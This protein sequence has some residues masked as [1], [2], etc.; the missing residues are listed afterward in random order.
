MF[1]TTARRVLA[2]AAS[3]AL[4]VPLTG[5]SAAS[6]SAD[7]PAPGTVLSSTRFTV[8]EELAA[9]TGS[10]RRIVYATTDPAGRT[11]VASGV[12]L[13]PKSA[14]RPTSSKRTTVAWLHG[15][16]GIA[17]PCA[18][19]LKP[20]LSSSTS[21]RHYART[22]A[23]LL[24]KGLTVTAPDYPG[25]GTSS[26]PIHPYLVRDSEARASIDAVRAARNLDGSLTN[27][28][29]AVG[30]SQGGQASLGAA[31]LAAS[32]GGGLNLRGAVAL[33]PAADF[34]LLAQ[35][36]PGTPGNGFLAMAAYGYSQVYPDVVP[37]VI[38]APPALG[39]AAG[40]DMLNQDGNPNQA[41]C[42]DQILPA[43]AGLSAQEAVS[44]G[45][46]PDPVLARFEANDVG[47]RSAGVPVLLLHRAD[48]QTIPEFVSADVQ[49]R[50]C[51]FGLPVQRTVYQPPTGANPELAHDDV[52]DQARTELLSWVTGRFS[53]A[54]A[55]SACP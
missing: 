38:L 10:A 8:S 3:A 47:Y 19:S 53:G 4:V 18:P 50:Y 39:I 15:T 52:L 49:A 29:V 1:T 22:V 24:S 13:T 34:A 44:G 25:L 9:T 26:V 41:G 51:G 28:W 42:Y 16:E 45:V 5:L 43:F 55:P 33:A 54:P 32:Y 35:F 40:I 7:G 21:Y 27:K 20:N 14:L 12:V 36:M 46:V 11:I 30:H 17:P 23:G 6:A 2:L 37:T 48:D 31:E